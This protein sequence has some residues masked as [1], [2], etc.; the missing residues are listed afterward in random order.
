MR[1]R[2]KT[3]LIIVGI[4]VLLIV[5]VILNLSRSESGLSVQTAEVEYGSIRSVVTATGELRARTQVNMQ[6]QVMGVVQNLYVQ[7]GDSVA[8]GDLLL[9]IDPR[10]YE[11]QLVQARARYTQAQLSHARVESLYSFRSTGSILVSDEQYESSL[12]AFEMARAQFA[13]AEDQREKTSIRAPV[14]GTVV[15][16]NVEEGETVIV[17]TMNS[18]GTVIMVIA[19]MSHM[20]AIVRVDETDVVSLEAGQHAEV[21]VDAAPDTVFTGTV[22]DIGYM[23]VQSLGLTS[24]EG[25]DFEVEIALASEPGESAV[26]TLRPGMSVSSDIVTAQLDSVLVVPIQAMGR[27]EVDDE[28]TETV[29]VVEN[30]KAVLKPIKTGESSDTEIEIIEGIGEGEQVITGPYKVLSKLKDGRSVK[31]KEKKSDDDEESDGQGRVRVR[32]GH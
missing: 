14:A 31:P 16:V 18:L 7:E 1:R 15:N 22:S 2:T 8:K 19:D 28:E 3:T 13:E 17:G 30:G 32:I 21:E 29:F 6:A 24:E 27:R 5:I 12:A 10:R 9:Q 11:A 4:L 26:S 23:P 20:L 25:V